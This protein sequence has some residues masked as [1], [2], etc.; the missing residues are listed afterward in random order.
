M[1]TPATVLADLRRRDETA[2]RITWYDLATGPT[3]GERVELSAR[4][5]ANWVAKAANL[6][7]EEWDV[8]PGDRVALDLPPHWRSLAWAFATWSAGATVVAGLDPGAEVL[9][10]TQGDHTA[11][12]GATVLVTLPALAR[13]A[14]VP[15]PGRVDDAREL[16]TYPD[17]FVATEEPGPDDV[18]LRVGTRAT[19]FAELASRLSR[20]GDLPADRVLVGTE[21]L[22]A[23]LTEALEAYAGGGSVVL[24][25][26]GGPERHEAIRTAER[27]TRG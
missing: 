7:L 5:L 20:A 27:V 19:T 22:A 23:F 1:L 15:V 24:V 17:V 4:V 16:A 2:P 14:T 13:A 9:V 18:A 25:R 6:L 8:G 21:D 26:G 3:E 11:A 10:T 12:S